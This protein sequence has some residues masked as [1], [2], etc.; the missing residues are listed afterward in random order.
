MEAIDYIIIISGVVL[1]I[2]VVVLLFRN[3]SNIKINLS[4]VSFFGR[5]SLKDEITNI[6]KYSDQLFKISSAKKR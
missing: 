4:D 6:L 5:N 3:Y 2:E 1:I